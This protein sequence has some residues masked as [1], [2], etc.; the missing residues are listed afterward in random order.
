MLSVIKQTRLF[1]LCI[2]ISFFHQISGVCSMG[3]FTNQHWQY[4]WNSSMGLTTGILLHLVPFGYNHSQVSNLPIAE[5]NNKPQDDNIPQGNQ[6]AIWWIVEYIG[7]FLSGKG[8]SHEYRCLIC[9]WTCLP[10]LQYFCPHNHSRTYRKYYLSLWFHVLHYLQPRT[11]FTEEEV[12]HW[13]QAHRIHWSY[14]VL[15]T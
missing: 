9:I 8:H 5:D 11:H 1:L 6:L 15:T 14:H 3:S 7:S 2:S 13:V 10:C 12:R 4:G